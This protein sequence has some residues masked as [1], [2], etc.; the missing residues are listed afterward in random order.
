MAKTRMRAGIERTY[1]VLMTGFLVF[2]LLSSITSASALETE[3][4]SRR[5]LVIDLGD[6]LTTE[7]QLTFPA[8]GEGP[9]PGVLLIPGGGAPDMDEYM[10][11]YSTESR[12]PARPHLQIA[13]Y[14]SERG[15]AVMRYNKRGVGFNSTLADPGARAHIQCF[16]P[17]LNV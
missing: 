16:E 13:E 8:V 15:F 2:M 4:I 14:L 3:T 10:P 6:G 11:P 9:F 17:S 5:D 7:A 12:E 1:E